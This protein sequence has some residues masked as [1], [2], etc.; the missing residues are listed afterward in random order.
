M[1]SFLQWLLPLQSINAASLQS[2]NVGSPLMPNVTDPDIALSIG[3][4][5]H[6]ALAPTPNG[7]NDSTFNI[8]SSGQFYVANSN[9]PSFNYLGIGPNPVY[10]INTCVWDAGIDGPSYNACTV[11]NINVVASSNTPPVLPSFLNFTVPQLV[12]AGTV[13]GYIN[14]TSPLS[15]AKLTYTL[16]ATGP[17]AYQT[18]PFA[19]NTVVDGGYNKGQIVTTSAAPLNFYN[20]NAFYAFVSATDNH[21]SPLTTTMSIEIHVGWTKTPPYFNACG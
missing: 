15:G 18:F 14:G 17:S 11:V 9:T 2:G 3:E 8:T 1:V 4:T 5:L 10:H 19:I 20:I 6:F 16:A 13:V 21:P 7:N 12:P